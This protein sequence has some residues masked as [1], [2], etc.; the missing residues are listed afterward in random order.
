MRTNLPYTITNIPRFSLA[1]VTCHIFL[2]IILCPSGALAQSK[3]ELVYQPRQ[4]VVKSIGIFKNKIFIGTGHG[5]L[6]SNDQGKNWSDFGSSQFLQDN[7]GNSTINW[8]YI[9]EEKEMIYAASSFGA[10]YSNIN[11][12]NWKK[13]FESTK[14]ESNAVNSISIH[15]N[16]AYISTNDGFWV[17]DLKKNVCIRQNQ[18]LKADSLTGNYQTYYFHVANNDFFLTASNGTY[19]L[20]KK[21]NS[22]QD[23]SN[24]IQ[25]L[26]NGRINAKHLL[27]DTNEKLWISTGSGIYFKDK[28]SWEKASHGI[29]K[30][31]D[32]FQ[33][34]FY[35]FK[36]NDLLFAACS[37]GIYVLS[38]TTPPYNWTDISFGIR[39]K[40]NTRN[41]YWIEK[42]KDNIYAATDEGLFTTRLSHI[43]S[44]SSK[45]KSTIALKGK[46]EIGLTSI[47]ALE[48]TVIEVQKQ[49]LKFAALPTEHDYKRYR[50]QARLRNL[51]PKIGFDISDTGTS[52]NYYELDRGISTD[53]A[54]DNKF[55]SD[56]TRRLQNDGR[57]FKQ[58][59]VSW[60]TNDFIYDDQINNLLNQ[61]RL[62]ANIR[63]NL[64][65]D[66]TR[67]YYQRRRLQL[68]HLLNKNI[69]LTEKL[70]KELEIKEL[71]GQLDSRTG[72]W[73]TSE[74]RK[75]KKKLEVSKK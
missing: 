64:L 71:T 24:Q 34:A 36:T 50:A 38:K 12:A 74:I 61:A 3:W 60:D 69:N 4:R 65:D 32:G 35:L 53:I 10:Y 75:R 31:N 44:Q 66:I 17:C 9:D 73:F 51:F 18:G 28:E 19:I 63:E 54:F 15:Q 45:K 42:H 23:I 33:E 37:S 58:F 46:V 7:T 39:T 40:E 1:H 52:T 27:K 55:N 11:Q 68:D 56:I 43:I 70:L 67:I 26:P 72:G 5:V 48:P 20:N 14:T 41:V 57:T 59:S 8:I 25:K 13:L 29:R 62:T 16:K 6:I 47:E 49:A 22:W 21:Q 2:L 30:N